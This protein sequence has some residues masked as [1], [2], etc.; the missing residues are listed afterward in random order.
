MFTCSNTTSYIYIYDSITNSMQQESI[1]EKENNKKLIEE[2]LRTV[3]S[4]D[5]FS[6]TF[7][8]GEID[9]N[10]DRFIEI[11][12]HVLKHT[13]YSSFFKSLR[14]GDKFIERTYETEGQAWLDIT[15]EV[16]K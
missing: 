2:K 11:D 3:T 14:K 13:K 10:E 6:E 12:G 5:H 9:L 7:G 1:N 8:D 4:E 16:L 15:Y